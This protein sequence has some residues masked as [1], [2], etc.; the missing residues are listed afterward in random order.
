MTQSKEDYLKLIYQEGGQNERISNKTIAD[1]LRIAPASVTEMLNKLHKDGYVDYLAYKGSKLT[2]KGLRAC[3]HVVRSHRLWEVF[4]M[5][6]LNYTWSEAHEDA[7]LL[8]HATPKRMT[9]RL[10]LFLNHPAYCPHGSAIPKSDGKLS[11][12]QLFALAD[13]SVG[14]SVFIRQVTEQKELLDYLQNKE[15]E[16]GKQAEI[17][18]KE[19]YEGPVTIQINEKQIK[20]SYKAANQIFVE[21]MHVR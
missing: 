12:V 8:E 1:K 10:D 2:D 21:K 7:H 9:E 17:I 16:I 13:I 3:I 4:L 18:S 11:S 5:R 20:I 19:D 14:I 6:H 15:V